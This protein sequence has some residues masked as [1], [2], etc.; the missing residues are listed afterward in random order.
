[1][2]SD[3]GIYILESRGPNYQLEYRVI[4][5]QAIENIYYGAAPGDDNPV[6]AEVKRYFDKAIVHDNKVR[7]W[8]EAMEKE[9]AIFNNA[10]PLE[11]GI[12]FLRHPQWS[13]PSDQEPL[14]EDTTI[15]LKYFAEWAHEAVE[16]LDFHGN[17]VP[18]RVQKLLAAESTS[19]ERR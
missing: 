16:V 5:A 4:H 10:M 14:V 17:P 19:T 15:W 1:M 6:D 7:A 9:Q 12:S 13:Y 3:N 2:S 11:Y 8:K 18:E